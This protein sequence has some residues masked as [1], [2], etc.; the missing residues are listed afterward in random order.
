MWRNPLKISRLP[1]QKSVDFRHEINKCLL[2]IPLGL[3]DYLL[4]SIIMVVNNWYR[5]EQQWDDQNMW[6]TS[7]EP[8]LQ[9]PVLNGFEIST[10]LTFFHCLGYYSAVSMPF[11]FEGCVFRSP[12]LDPDKLRIMALPFT[13]Y[14]LCIRIIEPWF[15]H[16]WNGLG[17]G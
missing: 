17:G 11:S 7:M 10:V 6:V 8:R 5:E 13:A 2:F 3:H 16:P 1:S 12:L 14:T 9:I 4:L 15:P